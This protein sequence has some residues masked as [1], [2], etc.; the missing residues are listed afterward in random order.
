MSRAAPSLAH[1]PTLSGETGVELY[2]DTLLDS[3]ADGVLSISPDR[4]IEVLNATGAAILGCSA[5]SAVGCSLAEAFLLDSANDAFVDAILEAVVADGGT[6][7]AV[8]DFARG[9]TPLRLAVAST[10]YMAKS[11]PYQGR[12][13]VVVTFN[14]VTEM[15][16]L[17]AAEVALE[18]DLAAKHAKLQGAYSQLE[19]ASLR[20][21]AQA[22]R[23]GLVRIGSAAAVALGVLAI[24]L[25][26]WRGAAPRLEP[27]GS[28]EVQMASRLTVVPRPVSSRVAVVGQI[29]AGSLVSVVGPFDGTVKDKRFAYGGSVERGQLLVVLDTGPMQVQLRDA[30]SARIKA[31]QTLDE[32][33]S[34]DSGTDVA[35]ARRAL[36]SAEVDR[37]NL[38]TKIAQTKQLLSKG[39]VAAEEYNQLVQQQYSLGIQLQSAKED[40]A[41]TLKRGSDENR[42]VAEFEMLN[43]QGKADELQNDL[44][45]AA[46]SAP[47]S[48]VVLQPPAT[49]SGTV[50]ALAVGSRVSRG[51]TM[52]TI[53]DLETYTIRAKVDEVDV[54]KIH[55]G[56]TADVTG[57]AF[58]D[59][60]LQGRVT[61]VAAQASADTSGRGNM[62]TFPITVEIAKLTPEQRARIHVGMSASVS[63]VT[64]DNPAALV[65][66]PAALTLEAGQHVLT[67]EV[68]G[69]PVPTPVTLGLSTP[70]GVEIRR[71]LKAGDV[72][73]VGG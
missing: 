45:S 26:A 47:V 17:R 67:V 10:A 32:L 55:V 53:G 34:W 29:D 20:E 33:R 8:V 39:I 73:Q 65:V 54:N 15:L 28:G 2:Y 57:D 66:P 21:V 35:R 5:A 7:K 6:V 63:I 64:Y 38:A 46:V 42:R 43:A 12:Q 49:A 13:G 69:R 27:R 25:Y 50:D 31:R 16:R 51:Q 22:R 56:Q 72:I 11:G 14:D 48:G 1:R 9:A 44:R 37:A 3:L 23:A 18:A 68:D 60:P 40:L 58:D 70:Q 52:F 24:G 71:G 59:T 62:A 19:A 61:S 4:T 41:T 36:A 30:E